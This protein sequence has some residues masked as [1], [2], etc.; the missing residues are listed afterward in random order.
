MPYY[1]PRIVTDSLVYCIDIKNTK[2]YPQTGN[3]V[4]DLAKNQNGTIQSGLAY[5]TTY[6]P[7]LSGN[8]SSS[9]YVDATNSLFN[10]GSDNFTYTAWARPDDANSTQVFYENRAN[11]LVGTLWV[12]YG[13]TSKMSLFLTDAPYTGQKTYQQSIAG[14]SSMGGQNTFFAI[15]CNRTSSLVK[16]YI[17]DKFYGSVSCASTTG[18][19]SDTGQLNRPCFDKGGAYWKSILYSFSIYKKELSWSEIL[20]N[21]NATKGRYS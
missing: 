15:T 7:G 5:N 13:G 14:P 3:T 11:S 16:Y 10:P 19:C 4:Y 18:S 21:Y 1:G 6:H 17:N 9:A 12:W 20:Q 8:G 2:S